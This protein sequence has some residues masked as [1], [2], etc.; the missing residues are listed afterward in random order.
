MKN[1]FKY[2]D[3]YVRQSDG[4]DMGLLKICLA[5]LGIMIGVCIPKKN[6]KPALITAGLVFVG[7]AVPQLVKFFRIVFGKKD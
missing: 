1:L 6:K 3:E 4:K 2:A 7:T 5:A